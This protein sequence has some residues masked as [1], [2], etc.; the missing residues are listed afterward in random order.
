M[1]TAA[2]FPYTWR[3]PGH[4]APSPTLPLRLTRRGVAVDLI[5]LV[6]SGAMLNVLPF[7]VGS[8]FGVDWDSLTRSV[9]VGGVGGGVPAKLLATDATIPPFAPVRL[10]FAWAKSNA[11]PTV[12]GYADFFLEFEVCFFAHQDTFHV[13]PRTP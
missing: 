13:R 4:L 6:D 1:T 8:R 5:A 9:S 3:S 7:D 2:V 12:L 11:L 10:L